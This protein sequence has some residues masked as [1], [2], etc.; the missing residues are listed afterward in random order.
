M[1]KAIYRTIAEELHT[2][3]SNGDLKPGDRVWSVREIE[4]RYNVSHITALRV[5][6]ELAAEE[7]IV[8]HDG[9]G[10]FVAPPEAKSR[11]NVL[12]CAFR[13]LVS[14]NEYDNFGNRIISGIMLRC[15][16]CGFALHI[17]PSAVSLSGRVPTVAE[18][19]RMATEIAAFK[20]PGGVIFDMRYSDEMLEKYLL[21]ACGSTPAVL[22]GRM[23]E[24]P[25]KTVSPPIPE[26]GNEAALL[27]LKTN[28]E[29]FIICP[30]VGAADQQLLVRSFQKKLLVSGIDP[31]KIIH[32]QEKYS[33]SD[34]AANIKLVRK[35]ADC[36]SRK[37]KTFLFSLN[38]FLGRRLCTEL[39]AREFHPGKDFALLTYGGFELTHNE[40]PRLTCISINPETMGSKAAEA[41]I[42]NSDTDQRK[43]Y[44]DYRIELND[45]F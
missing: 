38:D 29:Q 43:Y 18:V 15:V 14:Y 31:A 8:R 2:A 44:T 26:C 42:E 13:P 33:T 36:I 20:K 25:V 21:P 37:N 24:L 23:S 7:I 16:Q 11:N 3:I 4:E 17:P 19:E 40:S 6:R 39:L 10:Y 28:A 30:V 34:I 35:I 12:F 9:S 27:A 45:T 41:L 5:F 32:V 22:L 1:K